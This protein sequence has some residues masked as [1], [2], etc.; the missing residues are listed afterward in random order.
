MH[1]TL[2]TCAHTPQP[3]QRDPSIVV[4]HAVSSKFSAGQPKV[5]KHSLHPTHFSSST[6]YG[7]GRCGLILRTSSVAQR[8]RLTTKAI[9]G[10]LSILL[11]AASA[12]LRLLAST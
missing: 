6:T 7:T 12:A 3:I 10:A 8:C 11:K 4:L 9:P 5:D 1:P 2:Q